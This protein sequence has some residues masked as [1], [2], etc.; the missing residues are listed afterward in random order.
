MLRVSF[1][2]RVDA[3]LLEVAWASVTV[4]CDRLQH[5]STEYRCKSRAALDWI[6]V[7]LESA[8]GGR[9]D[10]KPGARTQH[11]EAVAEPN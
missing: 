6:D 4:W 1:Q 7:S 3:S 11:A 10:E 2:V 9:D 8:R 5:R